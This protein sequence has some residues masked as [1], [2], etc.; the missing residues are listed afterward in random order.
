MKTKQAAAEYWWGSVSIYQAN[1][2]KVERWLQA[3]PR[4]KFSVEEFLE[5]ISGTCDSQ[6]ESRQWLKEALWLLDYYLRV[7]PDKEIGDGDDDDWS[8]N[9][10]VWHGAFIAGREGRPDPNKRGYLIMPTRAEIEAWV[11]KNGGIVP[12]PEQPPAL[13]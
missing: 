6:K 9:M 7:F 4:V 11:A 12:L 1:Y 10:C 2:K 5:T 13:R 8:W 3:H